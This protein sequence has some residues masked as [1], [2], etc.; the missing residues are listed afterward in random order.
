MKLI[1]EKNMK[2][3]IKITRNKVA[4]GAL[5]ALLGL[6]SCQD[7]LDIEPKDKLNSDQVYRDIF[8][9]DAAV[10]GIYGKFMGLA[11]KYV[12]LNELRADLMSLTANADMYLQQINEHAVTKDNPYA[13]PK[14][15]YEVINNCND[16]LKN[17]KIMAEENKMD[18]G[19]F[20]E[21]YSDIGTLRS[22]LYLQLGI[23][24]GEVPY[25][26]EPIAN[27]DDVQNENLYPR[28]SLTALINELVDFTESLPYT[29]P[30]SANSTLVINV[31]GYNTAKFF[32]NK[33]CLLG[34][35]NLWANNYMQAAAHYK[36]VMETASN[37][38]SD[39]ERY[40]VYRVKWAEIAS[41]NDLAVGYIR[42]REQDARAL[43]NNNTQ[44]WRSMFAREKDVLW[45]TEWIWS[46]PFDSN[47][48]PQNPFVELF[49]N[50]GGDYLVKPSQE[51]MDLWDNQA[52][53]NGFSY[54]A[55]G[56]KFSYN[57]INGQPV[58]MKYLFKYLDSDT[59]LPI[60]VFQTGGDWFLYRA[61]TLHLR[62]AEAANRDNQHKIADAL[63]NFGIQNAYTVN[64]ITDV[65]NIEQT[66]QPSPYDFDARQGD[67]PFF[68]GNWYRNTG[69]RGRAYVERA[70]VMG[71]S[72]ISIENNLIKESALE[73]AY[74]GNRWGDLL[75]VALRRNDPAF[76]ADKVYN[77]LDKDGN[78]NAGGVRS[79]L[80]ST[81]NWYLPF[82]WNKEE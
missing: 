21:R 60:D 70:E 65:T 8:D 38:G 10:V 31:D 62:Y 57:I 26:T 61:A 46:L 45:N 82:V 13:N 51:A 72:L 78:P 7:Y 2:T 23:H 67:F 16:A 80:M 39:S 6:T 27:I 48:A 37:S 68:R 41:N 17:F 77:K 14:D 54:D 79:K 3:M 63:L 52:Q 34:D 20:N 44:G 66:H 53:R 42:Y 59:Q 56:S 19:E 32:I 76:L 55:R 25:V 47:F 5:V 64:G 18:Q 74:E 15:F 58:I 9:A 36:T 29:S 11:K 73:L 12:V 75:R 71:D 50:Q 81:S 30:Y 24:Y 4:L 35:L 49:S 33:E 1:L 22:W 28:L 43:V 40:D 69:I